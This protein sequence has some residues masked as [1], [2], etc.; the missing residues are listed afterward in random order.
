MTAAIAFPLS[1]DMRA[2]LDA[3]QTAVDCARAILRSPAP[4]TDATIREACHAMMTYGDQWDWAEAYPILKAMDKRAP[5]DRPPFSA[6]T[7]QIRAALLGIAMT[8]TV[9]WLGLVGVMAW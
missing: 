3:R 7:G 8:V 2:R 6:G 9:G 1:P 5:V 4:H